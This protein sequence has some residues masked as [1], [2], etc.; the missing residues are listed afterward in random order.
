MESQQDGAVTDDGAESLLDFIELGRTAPQWSAALP[1]LQQLRSHLTA[2]L[3]DQV[4]REGEP[5]GL[6]FLAAF[7]QNT[8]VGVAGWRVMANT[9]GIRILHVDDLVTDATVRGHGVGSALLSQ[10][11]DRGIAAGCRT[12]ELDSGVQRHDAHRFYLRERMAITAHHFDL[13]LPARG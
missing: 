2:D 12:L 8:C 9:S 5:Q 6:R 4:L 1:V 13:D 10:L 11:R 3:L 7:D